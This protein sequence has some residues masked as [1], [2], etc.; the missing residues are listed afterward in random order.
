[1]VNNSSVVSISSTG[2]TTTAL[3]ATG[4]ISLPN[5]SLT[6]AVLSDISGTY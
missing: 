3:I 1:L 4:T 5:N 6:C 2:F